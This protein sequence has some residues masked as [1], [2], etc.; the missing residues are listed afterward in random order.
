MYGEKSTSRVSKDSKQTI[1]RSERYKE[2]HSTENGEDDEMRRG[3]R[4]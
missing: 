1:D 3:E 2:K 4:Q